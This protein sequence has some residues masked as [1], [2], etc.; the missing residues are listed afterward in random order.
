MGKLN[1]IAFGAPWLRYLLGNIYALLAVALRV[2]NSH[3]IH[4]SKKF[5]D[6][7]RAI[8]RV[9]PSND[10]D[11]QCAFYSGATARSIHDCILLHHISRELRR[12]LRLIEQT[13]AS[14]HTP[15]TYLIAHLIPRIPY[16][17]ARSDSSLTA[18]GGYCPVAQ[19]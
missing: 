13:L 15:K 7:L 17:V 5:H 9:P 10:G 2:N 14:T 16:G 1:H 4:T 18:V 8:R 6:T 11:T 3:L 19:F 12:D